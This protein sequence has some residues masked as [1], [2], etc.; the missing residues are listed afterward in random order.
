MIA[1][2]LLLIVWAAFPHHPLI[3]FVAACGA[4]YCA[5]S[6]D[7]ALPD[8]ALSVTVWVFLGLAV[9]VYV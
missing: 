8:R 3:A 1:V 4:V 7:T 6:W 5:R 2:I 9:W